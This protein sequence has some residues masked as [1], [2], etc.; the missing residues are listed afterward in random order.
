M[1]QDLLRLKKKYRRVFIAGLSVGAL[2]AIHLANKFPDEVS[3]I[4]ALAPTVFYDG[5]SLH[6]GKFLLDVIWRIPFLRDSF[7]IRET[8]PHGLKDEHLR[9]LISRFYNN[10][11]KNQFDE[12]V[13][14]FGS[15]F[16]PAACLYQ[17]QLFVRV[18]KKELSSVKTP[19]LILHAVRMI[20]SV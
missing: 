8:T 6:K 4:V 20:W 19:I 14:S 15:P 17:H 3:G 16:F 18:V 1:V 10:A 2:M 5:W 7:M 9:S 11:K 12:K 13:A